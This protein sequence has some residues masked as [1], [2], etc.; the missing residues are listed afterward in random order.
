MY[1]KDITNII[2]AG[3]VYGFAGYGAGTLGGANP[4]LAAKISAVYSLVTSVSFA[5]LLHTRT[6][7]TSRMNHINFGCETIT[8][9]AARALNV[10]GNKGLAILGMYAVAR[11]VIVHNDW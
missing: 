11:Y 7:S 2:R 1:L 3:I 10:I 5:T 6:Y 4:I 8:I 9:V